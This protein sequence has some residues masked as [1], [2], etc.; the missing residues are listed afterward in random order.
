MSL[1]RIKTWVAEKLFYA[2]LN[3]EF[4]N[5]LNNG[6]GSLTSPRT[7]TFDM[8]GLA[9]ILDA[10]ADSYMVAATDDLVE[11]YLSGTSLYRFD[12]TVASPVNALGFTASA[13]GVATSINARGSDTN[14][15]INLVP[16]GTG[17]V[18]IG[19]V[20]A[21]MIKSLLNFGAV[22]DGATNDSAAVVSALAT[23]K[24]VYIPKTTNGYEFTS[25]HTTATAAWLIDPTLS[26][27]DATDDGQLNINR[28]FWTTDTAAGGNIW[29]FADRVF[30]G[31]AAG[32]FA[33]NKRDSTADAGNSW[34]D[35]G[36]DGPYFCARDAQ[37]LTMSS[38]G[39]IAVSGISR[40]SDQDGANTACIGVSGAVMNDKASGTAW[41][42]YSDVIRESGA[43]LT[44]GLEIA[45]KN[46]GT[47]VTSLPYTLANGVIGL[48]LAGGGDSSYGGAPTNPSNTAIEIINNSTTWNVGILFEDASL[49]GTDGV[50]GTGV[51]MSM[52][53]GH[54]LKWSYAG[55]NAGA[56]IRSEVDA[57]DSKTNMIFDDGTTQLVG[58]NDKIYFAAVQAT[59]Q[60]NYI[61]M[62]AAATAVAPEVKALG[63]DTNI[64]LYLRPKGTGSL[65]VVIDGATQFNVL[66]TASV[67]NYVE[68][69]G[70][71]TTAAPIYGV[72]GSD[73]NIDLALTPKGTGVV[74]FGTNTAKGAEA[75]ASYIT[76]KDAGGTAR[77]IMVC[78]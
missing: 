61:N 33:G 74:K 59:N 10:D 75:F 26:W 6:A 63:D 50:T 52:A 30:V 51:A 41:G 55:N 49:T 18:N 47:D 65:A 69:T 21:Q 11:L 42:L 13:T 12:G 57:A 67:V 56:S 58:Y 34:L 9:L 39:L 1:S 78:A 28:G 40:S 46:Q 37:N 73:T 54:T 44:C 35:S 7:A 53:R 5:I 17:T 72:A 20:D 22:G 19:G 3:A 4:D 71:A 8:N 76:I 45:A 29:R 62:L 14:I 77:K 16:K 23:G 66:R 68:V 32:H 25:S 27:S 60:V 24:L 36:T 64:N 43:G 15:S 31:Y 48:L 38:V 2:D 70:A